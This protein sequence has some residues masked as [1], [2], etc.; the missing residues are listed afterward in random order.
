M[1]NFIKVMRT[2]GR[3]EEFEALLQPTIK[4][5]IRDVKAKILV[6]KKRVR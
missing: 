4:E 1:T 6:S 5:Q 3:M 2:F